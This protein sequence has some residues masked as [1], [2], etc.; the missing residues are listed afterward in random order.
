MPDITI[1]RNKECPIQDSC[2][3]FLAKPSEIQQ[4][5][6][7]FFPVYDEHHNFIDCD[8]FKPLPE[9]EHPKKEKKN[10]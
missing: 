7:V 1:C 5:Y 10:V 4:S 2:Y 6:S 3:R 8:Y 9:F